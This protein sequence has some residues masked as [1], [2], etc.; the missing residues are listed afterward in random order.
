[1]NIQRFAISIALLSTL[2]FPALCCAA[3]KHGIKEDFIPAGKWEMSNGYPYC[4]PIGNRA[5]NPKR[6][7]AEL[8]AG[9]STG[10]YRWVGEC[11]ILEYSAQAH[12]FSAKLSCSQTSE[13]SGIKTSGPLFI[14]GNLVNPDRYEVI[15][16]APGN[17]RDATTYRK[18]SDT[19]SLNPKQ[20][21]IGPKTSIT[22]PLNPFLADLAGLPD[23]TEE[24]IP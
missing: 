18:V 24:N 21:I 19:C 8:A 3:A 15:T 7:A 20:T 23:G 5:P 9:S 2:S 4:V 17:Y 12:A 13:R 14:S 16:Q 11:K 22:Q 1:M 6:L 10:D